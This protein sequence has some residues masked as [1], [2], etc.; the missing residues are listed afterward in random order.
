MSLALDWKASSAR[1]SILEPRRRPETRRKETRPRHV[2]DKQRAAAGEYCRRRN[3][4]EHSRRIRLMFCCFIAVAAAF[5]GLLIVSVCLHVSVVQNEMK[6]RETQ[7]LIDLERRRQE[8][9]R[10]EIAAME[11]PARVEGIATGNLRMVQYTLAEYVE[12]P[13]YQFAQAKEKVVI[14]NGEAVVSDAA[15][16]GP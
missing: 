3:N 2:E 12:T 5:S 9:L 6:A 13:A 1:S 14:G 4:L 15:T 8:E 16:E 7:R 11:S 10:V